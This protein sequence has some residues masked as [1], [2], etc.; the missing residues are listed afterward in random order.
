MFVSGLMLPRSLDKPAGAYFR[1]KL[2]KLVWPWLMWT[3]LMTLLL[4]PSASEFGAP[5]LL[6]VHGSV[7]T[8][9]LFTVF[10]SYLLAWPLRSI[11]PLLAAALLAAISWVVP[12][13]GSWLRLL[14]RTTAM[15]AFFFLGAAFARY[16]QD[17]KSVPIPI[18][19]GG[20]LLAMI[21]TALVV[22]RG[23]GPDHASPAGFVTA[24]V[25]ILAA[26]WVASLTAHLKIIRLIGWFGRRSIV[27]YLVHW[28]LYVILVRVL[29]L[30][31]SWLTILGLT[32]TAMLL[33]AMLIIA[34]PWSRVMFESPV[35]LD[36][37]RPLKSTT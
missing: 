3:V 37:S 29:P 9:F 18:A 6:N 25:G 34:W 13:D 8:W 2:D 27:P 22:L 1:G 23:G 31:A 20:T 4:A 33:S 7:H 30:E 32:A 11:Q 19:V 10:I 5:W 16:G 17:P 21:T 12:D 15:S 28:P 24:C 26:S 36:I 14:E 35:Q